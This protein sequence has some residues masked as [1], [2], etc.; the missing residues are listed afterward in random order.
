MEI[1]QTGAFGPV[2]VRRRE[3]QPD[4]LPSEPDGEPEKTEDE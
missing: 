1:R 2:F 3:K 4:P